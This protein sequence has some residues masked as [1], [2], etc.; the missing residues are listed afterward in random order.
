MIVGGQEFRGIPN[1]QKVLKSWG[2]QIL[3]KIGLAAYLAEGDDEDDVESRGQL[4][5]PSLQLLTDHRERFSVV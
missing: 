5:F 2:P 4:W 1:V 3:E